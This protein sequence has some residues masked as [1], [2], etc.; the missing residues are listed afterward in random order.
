M[1]RGE[2]QTDGR[3]LLAAILNVAIVVAALVL[4]GVLVKKHLLPAANNSVSARTD[5]VR[6][7]MLSLPETNWQRNTKTLLLFLHS[8]CQ[9]CTLSAGF[10]GR[11]VEASRNSSD[12]K[13]LTVFS[14]ADRGS[15]QYL[16]NLNLSS[17]ESK[18]T[19]LSSLGINSTPTL[20]LVGADG[21]VLDVWK[22]QLSPK[23]E[24]SVIQTLGIQ[25]AG[26]TKEWYIDEDA[27]KRLISKKSAT[28]VDLR[29][30]ESYS[31][32]HVA[33][34]INI[35]FDELQVRAINELSTSDTIV[36]YG[37]Y[38]GD[39]KSESAETILAG[40]GFEDVL[41]LRRKRK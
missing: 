33:G 21:V 29:G 40:Q 8:E 18:K 6:G 5:I 35:P 25:K 12:I 34:A 19:D 22:G 13:L 38:D 27:L 1:T 7:D 11:L 14:D 15:E 3:K 23:K 9:Y 31:R 37:D 16:K 39:E 20:V 2:H 26:N 41:I 24:A 32:E 30:R 10:Y 17:L 4:S 28:V 36:V